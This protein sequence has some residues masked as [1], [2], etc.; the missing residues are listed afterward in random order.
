MNNMD[1]IRWLLPLGKEGKKRKMLTDIKP[2]IEDIIKVGL[3]KR[4]K[5]PK[6]K[7][8]RNRYRE[9]DIV[10]FK[11]GKNGHTSKYCNFQR[12]INKLDILGN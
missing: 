1:L 5:S 7:K 10:C 4:E 2:I 8:K 6:K 12:K 9:N 11:C 3:K